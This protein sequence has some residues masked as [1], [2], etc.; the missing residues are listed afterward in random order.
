MLYP[1]IQSFACVLVIFYIS[2]RVGTTCTTWRHT[3]T[4]ISSVRIDR[5]TFG[6]I[7]A[8]FVVRFMVLRNCSPRSMGR[9]RPTWHQ[10]AHLSCGSW[11]RTMPGP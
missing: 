4:Q 8:A 11:R 2:T 5:N 10:I 1:L 7:P 3:C 9:A 6:G